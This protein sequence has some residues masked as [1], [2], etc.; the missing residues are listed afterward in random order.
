[1]QETLLQHI[2]KFI[3]LTP[4]QEEIVLS[5][6]TFKEVI[7]KDFLLKEGQVC[8]SSY[9]ILK[10]CFRIYSLTEQ[11]GE[12]IIQ[13]AIDH[14]WMSDYMSLIAGTPS[15]FYMQAIE[16]SE[17]AILDKRSQEELLTAIPAL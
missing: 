11:G 2:R 6:F 12:Q 1:M 15:P 5:Y 14:W 10:G 9:F 8:H 7:K 4:E 13:F 17:I 16:P 3:S